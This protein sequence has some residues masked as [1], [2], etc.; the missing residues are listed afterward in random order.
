MKRKISAL[1]LCAALALTAGACSRQ[2]PETPSQDSTPSQSAVEKEPTPTPEPAPTPSPT[3]EPTPTA[4]P[5]PT[6]EAEEPLASEAEPGSFDALF[7]ENP[8]YDKLEEDLLLAS[9]ST[10]IQQ[11]YSNAVSLWQEAISLALKATQEVCPQDQAQKI[12]Q[13]QAEWEAGLEGETE[14]IRQEYEGDALS[15]YPVILELY[16]SRAEELYRAAYEAS[17]EM[18]PF[19]DVE[20]VG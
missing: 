1:I 13:E 20:A 11:A 18:P 2:Q 12:A 5:T 10:L 17:G 7:A 15:S 9:S 4:S 6:P 3:P 8:L 14:A 16:R 19:P